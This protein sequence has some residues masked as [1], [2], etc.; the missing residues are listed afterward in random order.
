MP[1]FPSNIASPAYRAPTPSMSPWNVNPW[2]NSSPFSYNP[3][4]PPPVSC[5][6]PFTPN[7][8]RISF[9]P[10]NKVFDLRGISN[11]IAPKPLGKLLFP[12]IF[13]FKHGSFFK[14]LIHMSGFQ[15][16]NINIAANKNSIELRAVKE[17]IEKQVQDFSGYILKQVARVFYFPEPIEESKIQISISDDVIGILVPWKQNAF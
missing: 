6:I 9:T 12:T 14:M 5:R 8:P 3:C 1:C 10:R 7:F 2:T 11:A 13:D 16:K 4:P 15:A 17:E